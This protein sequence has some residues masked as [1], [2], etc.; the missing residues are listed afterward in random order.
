[1]SIKS[2]IVFDFDG[3]MVHSNEIKEIAFYL[4]A[5]IKPKSN[6][7]ISGILKEGKVLYW[8]RFAILEKM[9]LVLGLNY[10]ELLQKYNEIVVNSLPKCKKREGIDKFLLK[11]SGKKFI[12]SATPYSFLKSSVDQIFGYGN[13]DLVLGD[14]A[15]NKI[16]NIEIIL[17]EFSL[18]ASSLIIIGDGQDDYETAH[19]FGCTFYGFYGGTIRNKKID[20]YQNFF[21]IMNVMRSCDDDFT[22]ELQ[23]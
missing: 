10:M 7:I 19:H 8:D 21:E 14:G 3:T 2:P 6:K 20:L 5:G 23:K 13:F 17:N 11:C 16:K 4:A 18:S 15:S 12:N 1:M 9:S 22:D